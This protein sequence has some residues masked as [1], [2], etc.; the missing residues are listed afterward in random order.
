MT[1]EYR[2]DQMHAPGGCGG[3]WKDPY[4]VTPGP[5]LVP[6]LSSL[7]PTSG[8]PGTTVTCLGSNFTETCQAWIANRGFDVTFVSAG[9]VSFDT[10]MIGDGST[11]GPYDVHIELF[12]EGED[13]HGLSSNTLTFTVTA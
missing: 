1:R 6:I 2:C 10:P 11:P 13:E 3:A 9:E 8:P 4:Q 12:P 5:S 7:S